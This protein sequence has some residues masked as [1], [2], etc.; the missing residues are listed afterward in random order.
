MKKFTC[1]YAL[2]APDNRLIE[3]SDKLALVTFWICNNLSSGSWIRRYTCFWMTEVA[4]SNSLGV[5]CTKEGRS[6]KSAGTIMRLWSIR[7]GPRSRARITSRRTALISRNQSQKNVGYV[8]RGV[9]WLA[10]AKGGFSG[11]SCH[12][13]ED[14]DI[15]TLKPVEDRFLSNLSSLK[16]RG[17]S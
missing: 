2:R 5:C 17:T 4:V 10:T 13:K 6:P 11:W 15:R 16:L 7:K 1:W 9:G 12:S 8:R 14:S 3:I